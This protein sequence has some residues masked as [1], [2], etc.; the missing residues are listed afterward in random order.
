MDRCR[1]VDDRHCNIENGV[2]DH[3]CMFDIQGEWL[4]GDYCDFKLRM[5]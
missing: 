3:G 2:C 4:L 5:L 1:R